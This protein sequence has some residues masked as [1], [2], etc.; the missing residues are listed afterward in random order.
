MLRELLR[1]TD[2]KALYFETYDRTVLP[3]LFQD[4]V[5]VRN[6]RFPHFLERKFD[7][8]KDEEELEKNRN[9]V[10]FQDRDRDPLDEE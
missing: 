3:D 8:E 9:P 7:V 10:P 6:R 2:K 4:L 1:L 5:L